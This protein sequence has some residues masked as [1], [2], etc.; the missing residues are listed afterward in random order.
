MSSETVPGQGTKPGAGP[1][2]V[3]RNAPERK[4]MWVVP[5]VILL[6]AIVVVAITGAEFRQMHA[7]ETIYRGPGVTAIGQL[8]DYH[9]ALRNSPA[10]T[11]VYFLEGE[12]PGGTVL[13]LG[14]THSN[15]MAGR[16]AAIIAIENGI[17][18]QGRL[19]IIPST[20][21]SGLTH[22][23]PS[24]AVPQ[25][26][27]IETAQGPRRFRYGDRLTNPLHQFPDPEMLVHYPSGA[28]GSGAEARNLNRNFPGRPDGTLT[29][30][31]AYAV[32][33][34]VRQ[35][36]VDFVLDMHEA[37]PMNPIVQAVVSHERAMDV[38]AWAL[39]EL[40]AFEGIHL[41]LEPS[42]QLFRGLTHRELG[43]H[44]DT[45]SVLSETAN[46]AMD[47]LR[48]PTNEELLLTGKDEFMERAVARPGL[49]YVDYDHEAGLHIDSRVGTQLSNFLK[50]VEVYSE[51]HPHR[52]VVLTGVPNYA[53]IQAQGTGAFLGG[54][55]TGR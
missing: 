25:F 7:F 39:M 50:L 26:F 51:L 12:Q 36:Q 27:H 29:E 33:E 54:V 6:A 4:T 31:V 10:E 48:G 53:E 45:L 3:T 16:L 47:W 23:A 17:V 52:P 21:A 18:Q 8:S 2:S 14:G 42:P 30:Q 24:Q 9:A 13:V 22:T 20:N 35:E 32:T 11:P 55:G 1:Q 44:T 15:E 28:L 37:R 5:T 41:R 34:L 38:T 19:I 46:V 49:V 43:D 40:Q